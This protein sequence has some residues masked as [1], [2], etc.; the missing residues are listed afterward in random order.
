MEVRAHS[1][2]AA[3][4]GVDPGH[5][6]HARR[7]RVL[8]GT[9]HMRKKHSQKRRRALTAMFVMIVACW[10]AGSAGCAGDGGRHLRGHGD[11]FGCADRGRHVCQ[12]EGAR[13][14]GRSGGES[15]GPGTSVPL[16][17]SRRSDS[18]LVA[19]TS[20]SCLTLL[21]L[22]CLPPLALSSLTLP[23]S[24]PWHLHYE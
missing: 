2:A 4:P 1:R 10:S 7:A 15:S 8:V 14:G 12:R 21:T 9:R 13:G 5:S 11:I 23:S 18:S 16:E 17:I 6:L 24:A 3:A 19:T 22:L 20:F